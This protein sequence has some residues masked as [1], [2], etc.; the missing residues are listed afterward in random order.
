VELSALKDVCTYS[1]EDEEQ[2][3]TTLE[4]LGHQVHHPTSLAQIHHTFLVEFYINWSNHVGAYYYLQQLDGDQTPKE[5][6]VE[7]TPLQAPEPDPNQEAEHSYQAPK[8][9][10][11]DTYT[12][13]EQAPSMDPV[14]PEASTR[15]NPTHETI[16][17][18]CSH[19]A[20]STST[21]NILAHWHTNLPLPTLNKPSWTHP[22]LHPLSQISPFQL[23]SP[24]MA[25]LQLQTTWALPKH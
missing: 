3:R 21:S 24:Q 15:Y 9:T 17:P 16:T 14:E 2:I 4:Y 22:K 1:E 5:D 18:G 19:Q 7:H 13:P 12:A 20:H 25:T 8:E 23:P 11:A 6:P 10:P